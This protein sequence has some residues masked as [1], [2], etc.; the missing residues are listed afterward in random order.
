[1][2]L[3]QKIRVK[4]NAEIKVSELPPTIMA[5]ELKKEVKTNNHEKISHLTCLF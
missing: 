1:M 5:K 2:L 4:N 3:L